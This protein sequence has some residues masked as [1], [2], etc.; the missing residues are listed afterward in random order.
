ME[1]LV[2]LLCVAL[3]GA[4]VVVLPPWRQLMRA[5]PTLP[6][7]KHFPELAGRA[8]FEAEMRC[9][10]CAGRNECRDRAAPLEAC[11]NK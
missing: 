11:P 10:A 2:L 6:V 5:G 8:A 3:V 7:H 4:L 9:A 1:I